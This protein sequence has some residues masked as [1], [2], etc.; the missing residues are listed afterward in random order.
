M[1]VQAELHQYSRSHKQECYN[2]TLHGR[3]LQGIYGVAKRLPGDLAAKQAV[4]F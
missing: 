1:P 2:N 4:L 3:M